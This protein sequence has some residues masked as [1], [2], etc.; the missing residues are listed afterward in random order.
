MSGRVRKE[1]ESAV[2]AIERGGVVIL[3]TD[4]VYGLACDAFDR[5]AVGRIYRLK[6]RDA[7]NPVV[8]FPSSFPQV[9]SLVNEMPVDAVPVLLNLWPGALTAVFRASAAVPDFITRGTGK[10]GLRMPD[11]ETALAVMRAFGKPLAVTSANM[12]GCPDPGTFGEAADAFSGCVDFALK[13]QEKAG[14]TVSTVVDF[15]CRPAKILR[16]GAMARA[17]IAKF[18]GRLL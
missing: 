5:R 9:A 16:R 10:V 11:D 6:G 2:G 1:I 15:S 4:T 3:P 13:G 8:L 12:S 17:R 14:R 18:A 7:L